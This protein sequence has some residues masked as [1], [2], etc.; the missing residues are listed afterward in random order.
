MDVNEYREE[1]RK[2]VWPFSAYRGSNEGMSMEEYRL[3]TE[4]AQTFIERREAELG[5]SMEKFLKSKQGV[6]RHYPRFVPRDAITVVTDELL[7]V[8]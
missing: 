2:G 7:A 1:I 4:L 8:L 5:I 3:K 6:N